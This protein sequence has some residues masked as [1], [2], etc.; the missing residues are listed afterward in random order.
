MSIVLHGIGLGGGIAI[1]QAYILDK[2]LADAVQ[3]TLE[4][5][6]VAKEIIRFEQAVRDTHQELNALRIN[7]P[8]D[9]PSELSVF[10]SLSIMMLKDKQ[11][12]ETPIEIIQ[13]KHCNSEWA[14]KVQTN[15]LVAQFEAMDDPYLKERSHDIVQIFERI[16]KNLDGNKFDWQKNTILEESILIAHDLSPVDLLNFKSSNFKGFITDI[17]SKTSHTAIIGRNLDIPAVLGVYNAR[18]LIREAEL[19]IVDGDNGIVIINPN[20]VILA[21]YRQ[22]QKNKS[23]SK[24]KLKSINKQSSITKD[25]V[26]I[27]LLAN[28]ES[29]NDLNEVIQS[30]AQGIGLFRSEFLFLNTYNHLADEHEQFLAYKKVIEEMA[31]KVVTIRTADLGTDKNPMWNTHYGK[32][33][34]PALGISGIRLSL[35]EHDLFST[36]LRAILRASHYGKAQIMFPM[37]SSAWEVKQSIET[38][39]EIKHQLRE[40]NIPFDEN[41]KI[42]SMIEVP[43]AAIAIKPILNL[44]D[45][46]SIGTNDLIQYT[47]AVDRNYESLNYLYD[48]AHPAILQL[49]WHVFK[50][51]KRVNLPVSIC[52]EMAGDCQMTR[53]LLGLGLRKF[54]THPLNIAKIKNIIIN[55]NITEIMPTIARIMRTEERKKI[56]MLLEILNDG[57]DEL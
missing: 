13:K 37:I 36:Q 47:L 26:E 34:N 38:I 35:A 6:E 31:P 1:N 12:S 42:G 40:E 57:I 51:A 43:A 2:S 14:I 24:R 48:S 33:A 52:G 30:N 9:A 23:K 7:I 15:R 41:I 53:L 55:S 21:Q 54:S 44:V 49:I 50:S 45:F 56:E 29:P 19:V 25:G 32:S 27:E 16:F 4:K 20:K 3:V 10:L 5:N 46:I 28:I 18:Q 11:I 22:I 8:S 39:E 17:G